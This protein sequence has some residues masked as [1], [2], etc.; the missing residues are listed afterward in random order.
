M[1]ISAVALNSVHN[2]LLGYFK[3]TGRNGIGELH[4]LHL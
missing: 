2:K 3:N 1:I 4:N